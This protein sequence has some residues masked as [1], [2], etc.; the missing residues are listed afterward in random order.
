MEETDPPVT[1]QNDQGYDGECTGKVIQ[2]VIEKT[3]GAHGSP[4]EAPGPA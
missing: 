4:E 3:Q 2:T 1:T